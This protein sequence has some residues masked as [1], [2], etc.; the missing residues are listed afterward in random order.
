MHVFTHTCM[1]PDAQSNACIS[2]A[3]TIP[4]DPETEPLGVYIRAHMYMNMYQKPG[5]LRDSVYWHLHVYIHI[6]M[7]KHSGM[8]QLMGNTY[9]YIYAYIHTYQDVEPLRNCAAH[10]HMH[11]HPGIIP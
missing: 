1:Y 4:Q 10:G 2:Q 8:M 5:A 11:E 6:R 3:Y 7:L 9:T